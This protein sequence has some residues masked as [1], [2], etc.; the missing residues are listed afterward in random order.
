[1]V[2]IP[3]PCSRLYKSQNLFIFNTNWDNDIGTLF[4]NLH[5]SQTLL[6]IVTQSRNAANLLKGV[7]VEGVFD[8]VPRMCGIPLG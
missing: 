5:T 2:L 8:S 7:D 3:G 6:T 1:M 4:N